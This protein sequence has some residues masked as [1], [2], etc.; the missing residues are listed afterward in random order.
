MKRKMRRTIKTIR[1][2]RVLSPQRVGRMKSRSYAGHATT[3]GHIARN[4]LDTH[5]DTCCAGANWALMELTGEVCEVTPFLDSYEPITEIPLARCGTVWTDPL[6]TQDYLL[7]GDQMLWFGSQLSNSLLNPNQI[8]AYGVGVFDNPFDPNTN[9]GVA[10]D[11]A[12]IPF[13]TKG[14]IIYFESRVPN[15]WELSHL[16]VILLTGEIW[17]PS[18]EIWRKKYEKQENIRDACDPSIYLWNH[19]SH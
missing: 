16:P 19:L 9:F 14:T 6:T 17:N 18:D 12:F 2:Q 4:E 5:A 3:E 13:D 11:E 7:V 8:R 1:T 10:S 15:E